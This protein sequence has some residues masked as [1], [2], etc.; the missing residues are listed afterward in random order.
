MTHTNPEHHKCTTNMLSLFH[1]FSPQEPGK[2]SIENH[3]PINC[4]NGIP[5]TIATINIIK[6]ISH[7]FNITKM[8]FYDKK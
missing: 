7:N 4:I 8:A 1:S 3:S 6:P 5:K 2:D